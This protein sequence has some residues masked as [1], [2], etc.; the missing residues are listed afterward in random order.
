MAVM[1]TTAS[2]NSSAEDFRLL[3][4]LLAPLLSRLFLRT[5]PM[6]SELFLRTPPLPLRA[7][8]VGGSTTD[9]F[10]VAGGLDSGDS[11]WSSS[12]SSSISCSSGCSA[13]AGCSMTEFLG[14]AGGVVTDDLGEAGGDTTDVFGVTGGDTTDVLGD[15]G[16]TLMDTEGT[17]GAVI[18]FSLTNLEDVV[19][20]CIALVTVV[21]LFISLIT[22]VTDVVFLRLMIMELE[23]MADTEDRPLL[24]TLED[25]EW[26]LAAAAAAPG[27]G[28]VCDLVTPWALGDL[29]GGETLPAASDRTLDEECCWR[30]LAAVG[31]AYP[32]TGFCVGVIGLWLGLTRPLDREDGLDGGLEPP[33]VG[34]LAV[35]DVAVEIPPLGDLFAVLLTMGAGCCCLKGDPLA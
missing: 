17:M 25:E 8:A 28:V 23:L 33:W 21:G 24:V 32:P 11:C 6:L 15:G 26:L 27:I 7:A 31:L 16:S 5:T 22:S 1:L 2:A 10:G 18:A 13:T 14:V 9:V 12:F 34:F 19:V 3:L 29:A 35:A 30:A 20:G 4:A